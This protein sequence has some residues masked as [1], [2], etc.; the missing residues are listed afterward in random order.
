MANFHSDIQ[1]YSI[2]AA[3]QVSLYFEVLNVIVRIS[4]PVEIELRS[5]KNLVIVEMPSFL[6]AAGHLLFLFG[7][8]GVAVFHINSHVYKSDGY[9]FVGIY[10]LVA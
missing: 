5:C 9:S 3:G 7:A 8:Q 10:D 1:A 2:C 4:I 6:K